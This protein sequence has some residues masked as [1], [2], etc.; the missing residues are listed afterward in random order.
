VKDKPA[1]LVPPGREGR[2]MVAGTF[3]GVKRQLG[4][5][6]DGVKRHLGLVRVHKGLEGG[7]GCLEDWWRQV[8]S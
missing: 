8:G 6:F 5:D 3:A 2:N 7:P 4:L 1:K